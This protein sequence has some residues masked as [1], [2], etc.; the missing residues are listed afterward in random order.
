MT[1]AT[2]IAVLKKRVYTRNAVLNERAKGEAR[3]S[4]LPKPLRKFNALDARAWIDTGA[5]VRVSAA[6]LLPVQRRRAALLGVTKPGGDKAVPVAAGHYG[7]AASVMMLPVVMSVADGPIGS[8]AEMA[9]RREE[10]QLFQ[11]ACAIGRHPGQ[12]AGRHD[13]QR[14]SSEWRRGML[15]ARTGQKRWKAWISLRFCRSS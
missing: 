2:R 15:S 4:A 1:A 14:H 11:I 6:I 5:G 10:C 13:R 9:Q 8:A 7:C 3:V 12:T